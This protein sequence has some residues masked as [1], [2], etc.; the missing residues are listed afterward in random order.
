VEGLRTHPRVTSRIAPLAEIAD[1]AG[2]CSAGR[3]EVELMPFPEDVVQQAWLR[4][5]S[6][7]ECGRAN[8]PHGRR[9][10]NK[11]LVEINKGREG[12]GNWETHRRSAGGSGTLNNCEILCWECHQAISW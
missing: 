5:G 6:R 4:A 11:T 1:W 10:C 12:E 2:E 8:H 3:K 9:R 7:C